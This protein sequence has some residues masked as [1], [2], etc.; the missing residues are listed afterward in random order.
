MCKKNIITQEAVEEEKIEDTGIENYAVEFVGE[1]A[2][3]K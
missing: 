3:E 1:T 2:N